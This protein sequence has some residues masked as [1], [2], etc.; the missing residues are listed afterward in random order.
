MIGLTGASAEV[1]V[2]V[3]YSIADVLAKAAFGIFIYT[4]AVRKSEPEAEVVEVE[5]AALRSLVAR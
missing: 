1:G 4:I 2:Q 3:G 5:P